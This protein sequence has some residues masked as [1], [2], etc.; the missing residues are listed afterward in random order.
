MIDENEPTS[1]DGP[2]NFAPFPIRSAAKQRW[3][4]HCVPGKSKEKTD[5]RDRTTDKQVEDVE[6]GIEHYIDENKASH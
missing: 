3:S 5:D 4:I 6:H 1:N 2:H